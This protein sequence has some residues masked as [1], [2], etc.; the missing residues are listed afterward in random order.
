MKIGIDRISLYSSHYYVDLKNLAIERNVDPE[1]FYLGIGQEKMAVP[2]P[3]EDVVT[4]GA[5]SAFPLKKSGELSD[6]DLLLFSTESGIDQSKAAGIYVH[7]LLELPHRC[8][9]VELKQACYSGTAALQLAIQY[10][11]RNPEKKALVIAADIARYD[12]GSPSEPTQGCG[13]VSL[14]ISANPRIIEIEEKSGFHTE[15]VM[16]FWRP[17]YRS[18]ALVDGKYS[19]QV[20][21]KILEACWKQYSE[22]SGNNYHD[23]DYFCYHIPFTKMAQKAHVKLSRAMNIKL[24][25]EMKENDLNGSLNYSRLMGNSYTASIYV[26]LTSLLDTVDKNL[27]GSRVGLFSYGSG[28]VG[29]FFS[30]IIQ[31]EYKKFLYASDHKCM[32]DNRSALNY[33]QY[34]DMFNHV[35]PTDGG[36]YIFPQY[37]TG[38]F[39]LSG[40]K[41]HKR[42]YESV[43]D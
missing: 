43:V 5:N 30:G 8:R 9:T 20:Y 37:K 32:L 6:V 13:A 14:L 7:Q 1:K 23:I 27:A 34:E 2:A 12:L 18:E 21:M 33:Q 42:L 28:C 17:N 19:V 3:D 38:P 29:E 16:D 4:L 11:A 41:E 39:R 22:L 10:V 26:G 40:I 35:V 24:T 36:D 15:D 31:S 25:D